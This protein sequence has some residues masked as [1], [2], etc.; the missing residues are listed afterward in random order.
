MGEYFVSRNQK[1]KVTEATGQTQPASSV[2]WD[3]WGEYI[4][5]QK[6]AYKYEVYV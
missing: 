1:K 4:F 5:S 6:Y 3:F 2:I